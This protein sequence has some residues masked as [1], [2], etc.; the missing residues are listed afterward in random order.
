MNTIHHERNHKPNYDLII[1]KNKNGIEPPKSTALT[2]YHNDTK[3]TSKTN[4]TAQTPHSQISEKMQKN[5][6]HTYITIPH[7]SDTEIREKTNKQVALLT[8]TK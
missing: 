7:P 3:L 5:K 6:L 1:E 8:I 2:L 4:T